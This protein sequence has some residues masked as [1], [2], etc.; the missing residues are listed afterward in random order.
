[1][2]DDAVSLFEFLTNNDL[3]IKMKFGFANYCHF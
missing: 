2:G 3:K 1:M